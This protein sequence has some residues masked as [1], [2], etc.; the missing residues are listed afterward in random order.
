M[1]AATG[2]GEPVELGTPVDGGDP[3]RVTV[4]DG[5]TGARDSVATGAVLPAEGG[6]SVGEGALG[7]LPGEPDAPEPTGVPHDA[8]ATK[9][10]HI[11]TLNRRVTT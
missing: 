11:K 10:R 3:D 9:P 6:T 4:G 2:D 7:P 8:R 5:A 1:S